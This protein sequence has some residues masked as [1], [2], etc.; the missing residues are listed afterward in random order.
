MN[1]RSWWFPT[2][3]FVAPVCAAIFALAFLVEAAGY[4]IWWP[5]L[6]AIVFLLPLWPFVD[7]ARR[8]GRHRASLRG[9]GEGPW[10]PGV[11]PKDVLIDGLVFAGLFAW[12]IGG[13]AGA[14][15]V[16]VET[17]REDDSWFVGI[18]MACVLVPLLVVSRSVKRWRGWRGSADLLRWSSQ[19]AA[20]WPTTSGVLSLLFGVAGVAAASWGIVTG[21]GSLLPSLFIA[22]GALMMLRRSQR[23]L[24]SA[25]ASS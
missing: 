8:E 13:M 19:V 22:W 2:A 3:V 4:Q 9:P 17:G 6:P 10:R 15:V 21:G 23:M 18:A 1:E 16:A 5:L 14:V 25:Q 12:F 11:V 20:R 24:R 7:L